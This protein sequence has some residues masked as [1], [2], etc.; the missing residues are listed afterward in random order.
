MEYSPP[1]KM[2][3]LWILTD[4]KTE[5]IY[6][7]QALAELLNIPYELK[8]I[9]FNFLKYLPN[10]WIGN[11]RMTVDEYYSSDIT[12]PY[13]D[14]VISA[15]KYTSPIALSLKK[16]EPKI[17][18]VQILKPR[19]KPEKFDLVIMPEYEPLTS[20]ANNV[21][22]SIGA[23]NK[24]NPALME[25]EKQ[26]FRDNFP[27]C[28]F[29]VFGAY[30]GGRYKNCRISEEE[31]NSLAHMLQRVVDNHG[32]QIFIV[33]ASDSPEYVK[34]VFYDH[35]YYSHSAYIYDPEIGG[36]DPYW[37]I[38]SIANSMIVT[39]D[40][41]TRCSEVITAGTPLYIYKP[42]SLNSKKHEYFFNRLTEM[43]LA[44]FINLNT[45]YLENYNYSPLAETR[46]IAGYIKEHLL[47]QVP[48]YASDKL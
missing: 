18:L 44:K 7:A 25:R 34:N 38:V 17:K 39:G 32:A 37:G 42:G 6:Q 15:G 28:A 36:Y 2:I 21:Y 35:F 46:Q 31:A 40:A 27:Q 26:K 24:I 41:I 9:K 47:H 33:F 30:I 5:N 19:E 12:A 23:M 43:Q 1:A 8:I 20:S 48:E 11:K 29:S 4:D 14:I 13:P 3:K 10:S 45:H 22:T 16:S